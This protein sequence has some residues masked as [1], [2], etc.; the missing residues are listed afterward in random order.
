M[1]TRRSTRMAGT[2]LLPPLNDPSIPGTVEAFGT[3]E[4]RSIA[5]HQAWSKLCA[6]PQETLA[7][8]S[9]EQKVVVKEW[10]MEFQ[11]QS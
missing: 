11:V 6:V 7:R 1:L 10:L 5:F 8:L 4:E 2:E 3:T 9:E